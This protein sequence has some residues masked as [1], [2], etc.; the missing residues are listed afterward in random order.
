MVKAVY[1]GS[2]DPVTAG[3]LDII[4]RAAR[5]F[6]HIVVT[7]F[8]NPAKEPLF[9]VQERMAMLREV[10]SHLPNV[11]VDA[12]EGLLIPYVRRVGAHVIIKGLR[13]M[14]D[15]DYE[16]RMALMNK[17]L[18]PEVETVFIL[19]SSQYA[20][21]SSSLIK[22]VASLG[23]CVAGLVPAAVERRLREMWP[24]AAQ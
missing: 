23:G 3:H 7:V 12:S 5:V 15:F 14:S 10:T 11:E 16:F 22:E 19:T 4:E 8:N 24:P 6:D 2:F 20:Y 9:S 13:A 18:D 17:K 21:L 1:P